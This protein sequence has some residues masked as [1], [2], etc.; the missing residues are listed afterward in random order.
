MI[1]SDLSDCVILVTVKVSTLNGCN[2]RLV[3]QACSYLIRKWC[4]F[5]IRGRFMYFDMIYCV[6][7]V[8]DVF[9][10]PLFWLYR[11]LDVLERW[12][13]SKV[14]D[15]R[16]KVEIAVTFFTSGLK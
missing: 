14:S 5:L 11:G 8:Q 10:T 3:S 6:I 9:N 7:H 15:I 1:L 4:L 13:D 2:A 16:H 12:S